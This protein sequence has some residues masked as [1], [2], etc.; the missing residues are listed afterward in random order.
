MDP[1]TGKTL[2]MLSHLRWLHSSC[3]VSDVLV[4]APRTALGAWRRDIED[5]PEGLPPVMLASVDS[6]WQSVRPSAG[7][8]R[9][10][11]PRCE[12]DRHWDVVVVDESQKIKSYSN[13]TR[14][15]LAI[16]RRADRR[17]I[18]SGTPCPGGR[19]QDLYYQF[20]FLDPSSVP[21]SRDAYFARYVTKYD[22]FN[23]PVKWDTDAVLDLIRAHSVQ[24]R[25]KDCLSLPPVLP[26]VIVGV[27]LAESA[28]YKKIKAGK[29]T[30]LGI[31]PDTPGAKWSKMMQVCSGSVITDDGTCIPLRS[32]KD[33]ALRDVI[34]A[35]DGKIVVFY[36]YN[37]SLGRI[38]AVC[39]SLGVS[40]MD[41]VDSGPDSWREWQADDT[42]VFVTQYAR[43]SASIDLFSSSVMVFFEICTSPE[44]HEQARARIDRIG[45]KEPCEYIYLATEGTIERRILD[46][47][48]A[49]KEVS[50]ALAEKWASEPDPLPPP[51]RLPSV[52][53]C[54]VSVHPRK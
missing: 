41:Y 47:V 39:D 37:G 30:G 9:R 25:K 50:E 3:G 54:R 42:R 19:F 11:V 6:V 46:D 1:G 13:R 48:R 7:S 33:E 43:G 18:L 8:R 34:E 20:R 49:G 32:D 17:Y 51:P 27:P 44:L 23:N 28:L 14:A 24:A 29:D 2:T 35:H 10:I 4:I 21:T 52:T 38:R 15:C 40:H 22:F 45:Q 53:S 12:Y 16:G 26:D 31:D 5:D 36:W